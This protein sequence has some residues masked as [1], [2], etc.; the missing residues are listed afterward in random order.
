MGT[1]SFEEFREVPIHNGFH[2]L[3]IDVGKPNT[4][5]G[6]HHQKASEHYQIEKLLGFVGG[7]RYLY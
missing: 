5:V 6:S 7:Y 3:A 1:Y 2:D 4:E